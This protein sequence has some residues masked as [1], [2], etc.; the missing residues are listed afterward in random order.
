M[1]T[2]TSGSTDSPTVLQSCQTGGRLGPIVSLGQPRTEKAA[3]NGSSG[4]PF[5]YSNVEKNDINTVNT[6]NCDSA[7][8]NP[9]VYRSF[10]MRLAGPAVCGQYVGVLT[11]LTQ[12]TGTESRPTEQSAR[13]TERS[14]KSGPAI[15]P[16]AVAEVITSKPFI[17]APWPVGP[18]R[19]GLSQ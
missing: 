10:W 2:P 1:T 18:G 4:E 5:L 3:R 15:I 11:L 17:P 8:G 9:C 14:T 7:A 19:K 13:A 6:A 16:A 12:P